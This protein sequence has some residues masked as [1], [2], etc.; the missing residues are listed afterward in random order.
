MD[1]F[2]V[3]DNINKRYT[4]DLTMIDKDGDICYQDGGK[5]CNGEHPEDFTIEHDLG[6]KDRNGTLIYDGD[7]V[8]FTYFDYN[9]KD[10]CMVGVIKYE[11]FGLMIK[12]V[13][14]EH[15]ED[16]TGYKSCEGKMYLT[17]WLGEFDFDPDNDFEIIGNIHEMEKENE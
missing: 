15:F 9:G 5:Y 17:C 7:V 16:F 8:R 3:Y 4:E 12:G 6:L 14:G 2:R 10:Y 11:M 1:R 13:K